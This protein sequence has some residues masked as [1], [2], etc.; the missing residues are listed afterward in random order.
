M[1]VNIFKSKRPKL[2]REMPYQLKMTTVVA[3]CAAK[4]QQKPARIDGYV[5]TPTRTVRMQVLMQPSP[6]CITN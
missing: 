6:L 1:R 5:K 3:A 2:G 4:I